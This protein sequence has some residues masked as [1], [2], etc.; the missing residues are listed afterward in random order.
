MVGDLWIIQEAGKIRADLNGIEGVS[1]DGSI[2]EYKISDF[3]GYLL[4]PN[5]LEVKKRL[6]GC[7]IH[8]RRRRLNKIREKISRIFPAKLQ[9]LI[10]TGNFPPEVLLSNS[11]LRI[12]ALKDPDLEAHFLKI[13]ELLRSYDSVTKR[14]PQL[15]PRKIA[16]VIG[17]CEDIGANLSYLKLQGSLEEKLKYLAN[18]ICKDVGVVLRKAQIADGLFEL[19]GF[20][21]EAFDAAGS[22]RLISFLKDGKPKLCLLNRD[23]KIAPWIDA[24]RLLNYLCLLQHSIRVNPSLRNVFNLFRQGKAKAVKLFFNRKLE[25]DYS[26]VHFPKIYREVFNTYNVKSNQRNLVKPSLNYLQ[27]GVSLNYVPLTDS[28]EDRLHTHISILHDLRALEALKNNLPQVYSEISKGAFISE[29][30]RF[31]LLDSIEGHSH[32]H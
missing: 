8:Y 14:L 13:Q 26:K 3:A 12:P 30:G 1:D 2:K 11:K 25:I 18:F 17:I 32:V 4:N 24:G 31:Y 9:G 20:N 22:H 27:I 28:G 15:N 29:A 16:H 10:N 7:E 6:I 19:R 23:D 21:F 5:P